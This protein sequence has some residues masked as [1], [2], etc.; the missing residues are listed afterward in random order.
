MVTPIQKAIQ[1][2]IK[3]VC[4]YSIDLHN[5]FLQVIDFIDIISQ[6][7]ISHFPSSIL[8]LCYWSFLWSLYITIYGSKNWQ[9]RV[10]SKRIRQITLFLCHPIWFIRNLVSPELLCGCWTQGNNYLCMSCKLFTKSTN[11]L[12]KIQTLFYPI[13]LYCFVLMKNDEKQN[14]IDSDWLKDT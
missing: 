3:A 5:S 4:C 13:R 12:K 1:I 2:Q 6:K 10:W 7:W 8:F 11:E 14:K 9:S